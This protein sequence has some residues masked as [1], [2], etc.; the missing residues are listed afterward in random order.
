MR[1]KPE[2]IPAELR[3][4]DRWVIWR[5]EERGGKLTK[6]PH[7]G[8]AGGPSGASEKWR[9]TWCSFSD[10]LEWVEHGEA[11]GIGF[12]FTDEDDILGI[13]LDDCRDLETGE[14]ASWA[15]PIIMGL[16][17]YSEV[18]PS[19]A[20]VHVLCH[21]ELPPGSR[22]KG[23][24]EMYEQG[25]YFTVTGERLP[26]LPQDLKRRTPAL[27]RLHGEIFPAAESERSTS[28]N[29]G[30]AA[31]IS[32]Q[33]I[34][35]KVQENA[36][37]RALWRGD[38]TG[39]ASQS[40]ADLALSGY[41]A[42]FIGH[43]P[44]AVDR[45]FRRSDLMRAKWD[46]L[47]GTSTYGSL[48]TAKALSGI[49]EFYDWNRPEGEQ[50]GFAASPALVIEEPAPGETTRPRPK[51]ITMAEL[52]K[53]EFGPIQWAIPRMVGEGVTILAG[54][55]KCGKSWLALMFGI[56]VGGGGRVLGSPKVAPG[57]VLYLALED[58][59][60]RIQERH[61]LLDPKAE[62]SER[63]VLSFEWPTFDQGGIQ[64]IEAWLSAHPEARLVIV[65]V[66]ALVRP[67][68]RSG[69][70]Q[71]D[72]DYALLGR[73]KRVAREYGVSIL[74]LTHTRKMTAPDPYDLIRGSVAMAGAPD[75]LM[76]L[77]RQRDEPEATLHFIGRDVGGVALHLR[78]NEERTIWEEHGDA[79]EYEMSEKRQ[80]I[81][82]L[83][84][85][86][87]DALSP[88]D[89]AEV[90]NITRGDAKVTLMRMVQDGQC[91]RRERGRYTLSDFDRSALSGEKGVLTLS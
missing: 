35:D 41:I 13:D 15:G 58:S 17:S 8:I 12:V 25:R 65:D 75:G 38:T 63:V 26:D 71:Y 61:L 89:V 19:G 23:D 66:L 42:W 54:G 33:T 62:G 4:I 37:Y 24:I 91:V 76:V 49:R 47:H 53:I 64:E 57:D 86:F 34:V 2:N 20:G 40:E 39:Y 85:Q 48:T 10:A 50:K 84:H 73:L 32:D 5:Y 56:A 43:D 82:K 16:S 36:K 29:G 87:A 21:G 9:E 27:A 22:R 18:T 88:Q 78:W 28:E 46:E 81:R 74:L 83:L 59:D 1:I 90:L 31:V 52:M 69:A 14:I 68:R 6:V 44:Q 30:A 67:G 45:I 70:D 3:G 7:S 80:R 79:A 55:P 51:F 77:M 11:D 60:R 72:E